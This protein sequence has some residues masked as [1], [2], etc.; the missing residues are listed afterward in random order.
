MHFHIIPT[1]YRPPL[2]CNI[3]SYFIMDTESEGY[4]MLTI[5]EVSRSHQVSTRMLR[6]YEQQGKVR[7]INGEQDIESIS[8]Q[9]L[10]AI[11]AKA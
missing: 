1:K 6:Y 2:D 9:I 7:L 8:Q 4:A 11:G 10:T 3:V 5:T